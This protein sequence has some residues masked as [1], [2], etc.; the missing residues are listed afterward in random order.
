MRRSLALLPEM[1]GMQVEALPL[2]EDAGTGERHEAVGGCVGLDRGIGETGYGG[3]Q[4]VERRWLV[5]DAVRPREFPYEIC[6][7]DLA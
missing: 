3:R 1:G 5:G 6:D 4:G 7:G 2:G